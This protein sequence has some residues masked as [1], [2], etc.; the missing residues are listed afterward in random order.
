MPILDSYAEK[1][2]ELWPGAVR[3]VAS[4]PDAHAAI[5]AGLATIR[6]IADSLMGDADLLSRGS[7]DILPRGSAA[8]QALEAARSFS[9]SFGALDAPPL[10][11]A[12][13]GAVCD[14]V[15]RAMRH[16]GKLSFAAATSGDA[17]AFH[18]AGVVLPSDLV[19]LPLVMG[20]F[21]QA[22][23]ARIGEG[24]VAL[25]G[26]GRHFP[27]SGVADL[28]AVQSDSA[29][30]ASLVAAALADAAQWSS[31]K[32]SRRR[33]ADPF[34]ARAY[35]NHPRTE[36]AGLMPPED[37]WETLSKGVKRAN[38]LRDKRQL[39][40]CAFGLKGRGRIVGPLGGDRLLRFGVS[41]WR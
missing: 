11:V 16:A 3:F 37:I 33:I 7:F 36:H 17:L 39:Q 21:V 24:G 27:T 23:G 13:P 41:E 18:V 25:S 12:L 31:A 22:L 34:V 38:Q 1:S 14:E 8:R 9:L 26:A 6:E 2:F 19:S 30:Q 29:A 5:E 35:E 40:A 28:V 32:P 20:E 10:L 4:G 15:M